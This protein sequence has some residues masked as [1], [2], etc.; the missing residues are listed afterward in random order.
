M[1]KNRKKI[2][3]PGDH[4]KKRLSYQIQKKIVIMEKVR[5]S[6]FPIYLLPWILSLLSCKNPSPS[7]ST[8]SQE[9]GC[10]GKTR[11]CFT[12]G[13]FPIPPGGEWQGYQAIPLSNPTSLAVVEIEITQKSAISHHFIVGKWTLDLPPPSPGVFPLE[14]VEGLLLAGYT[15]T[16]LGS[17]FRYVRFHT[18]NNIGIRIPENTWIVLNGHYINPT[19]KETEGYTTVF[20]HAVKEE[21]V[22]FL[23]HLELPG[24]VDILVPPGEVRSTTVYW[25]PPTDSALLLLT[26]HMHRHGILFQVYHEKLRSSLPPSLIYES[27]EY[28]APPLLVFSGPPTG[29]E[30]IVLRK[31]EDRLK[32]I[33]TYHNYDLNK[34]ITYGPSAY[35]DEMCI[36]PVYFVPDPDRFLTY[37]RNTPYEKPSM[38]VIPYK[39]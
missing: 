7:P 12:Y 4:R 6:L 28:E 35:T 37:F 13:P 21:E 16:L 14:T 29:P 19:E 11:F 26:S 36:M 9:K 1:E 25:E 17:V 33:C 23:A 22:P 15:H 24:T 39:E 10:D 5:K 27:R 2:D 31:G 30:P 32:F 8:F 18:G 34:P 20:I 3:L 38:T